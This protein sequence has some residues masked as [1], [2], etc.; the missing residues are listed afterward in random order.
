MN[1]SVVSINWTASGVI[2]SLRYG[3]RLAREAIGGQMG[4]T[5]FSAWI[6]INF[7]TITM[8][9]DIQSE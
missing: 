8:T 3:C 2:Y 6:F 1:F 5:Y 9:Y 4:W 7:R